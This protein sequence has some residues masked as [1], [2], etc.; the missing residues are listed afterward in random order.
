MIAEDHGA[1]SL[2]GVARP[3]KK[4]IRDLNFRRPQ[5]GRYLAERRPSEDVPAFYAHD[6][7]RLKL[8]NREETTAVN[9][10]DFDCRLRREIGEWLGHQQSY[11]TATVTADVELEDPMLT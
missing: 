1:L 3:D 9:R 11:C 2:N 7:V 10:T 8:A 6:L 4:V 5:D